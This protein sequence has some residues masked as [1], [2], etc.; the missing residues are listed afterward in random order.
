MAVTAKIA[1]FW[2]VTLYIFAS[3]S[4]EGAVSFFSVGDTSV[5][6][7]RWKQHVPRTNVLYGSNVTGIYTYT[8]K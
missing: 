8:Y 3:V 4:E 2:V 7:W 5:I 1:M 6:T